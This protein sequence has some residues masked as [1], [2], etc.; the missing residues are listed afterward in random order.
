M[1]IEITTDLSVC[2]CVYTLV[3]STEMALEKW[4]TSSN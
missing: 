1:H 3:L 2:V 4:C